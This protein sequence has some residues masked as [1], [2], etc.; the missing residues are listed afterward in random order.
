MLDGTRGVRGTG[1]WVGAGGNCLVASR[2]AAAVC[3]FGAK[4]LADN[5][6]LIPFVV[7]RK[8][9]KQQARA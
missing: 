8:E 2:V 1:V 5:S 9:S 6:L 4:T 7:Q 3:F